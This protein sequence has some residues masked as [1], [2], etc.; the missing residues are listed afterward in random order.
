VP[1]EDFPHRNDTA[2]YRAHAGLPV[3]DAPR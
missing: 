1:A 2:W 3:I